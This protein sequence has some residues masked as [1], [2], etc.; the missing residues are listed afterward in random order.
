MT[1]KCLWSGGRKHQRRR[2]RS[3][4]SLNG[5]AIQEARFAR[6]LARMIAGILSI[7]QIK[8]LERIIIVHN[9]AEFKRRSLR[10]Y[11]M[12]VNRCRDKIFPPSS[13]E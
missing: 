12:K 10:I 5:V 3:M 13:G 6:R 8:L 7:G 1:M 9:A 11:Q 4:R 2:R